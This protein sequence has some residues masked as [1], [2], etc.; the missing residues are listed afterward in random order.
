MKNIFIVG[1]KSVMCSRIVIAM[2]FFAC[3][4]SVSYAQLR[5]TAKFENVK[6]SLNY[7]LRR[8]LVDDVYYYYVSLPNYSK[9]FD[10]VVFWLGTKET[11]LQ[12][13]SDLSAALKEGKKGECFE[14]SACGEDYNLYYAKAGGQKCFKVYESISISSDFGRFYKMSIDAVLKYMQENFDTL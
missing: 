5:K 9:H 3:S 11:A 4:Y 13:L 7:S 2:L 8:A 10:P 14:Y 1:A 12:N 6:T